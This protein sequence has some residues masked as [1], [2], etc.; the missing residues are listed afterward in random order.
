MRMRTH[1]HCD[2][3]NAHRFE[4]IRS[5]KRHRQGS[6]PTPRV[7]PLTLLPANPESRRSRHPFP[8]EAEPDN[9]DVLRATYE[10]ITKWLVED[11]A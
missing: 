9:R 5:E 11:V 3:L 2:P 6:A 7:Q 1:D 8:A 10:A 4:G